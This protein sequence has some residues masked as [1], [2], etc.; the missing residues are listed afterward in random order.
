MSGGT[1]S[2]WI[3][4]PGHGHSQRADKDSSSSHPRRLP[5]HK[6]LGWP[7]ALAAPQAP[8]IDGL[9]VEVCADGGGR[10]RGVRYGVSARLTDVNLRDGDFQSSAGHLG[11]EKISPSQGGVNTGLGCLLPKTD[12]GSP[13]QAT[14]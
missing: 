8:Y 14:K 1:A 5:R 13:L 6:A 3:R 9:P 2:S 12:S 10:G 11:K 4:E 7:S